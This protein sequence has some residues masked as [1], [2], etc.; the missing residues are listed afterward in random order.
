MNPGTMMACIRGIIR[1]HNGDLI[2]AY[3]S[4]IKVMTPLEAENRALYQGI[5]QCKVNLSRREIIEGDYLVLIENI[6]NQTM[7]S[8]AIIHWWMKLLQ[9]LEGIPEWCI[10]FGRRSKNVVAHNLSKLNYSAFTTFKS[11]HPPV[12]QH[13]FIQKYQGH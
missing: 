8:W 10:R 11:Y 6:Q 3:T 12:V 7:V 4:S 1:N 5:I 2:V 9:A 13:L